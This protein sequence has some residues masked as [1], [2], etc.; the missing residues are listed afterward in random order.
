MF[1]EESPKSFL[2]DLGDLSREPW[3]LLPPSGDFLAEI[4]TRRYDTL[5]Y[6]RSSDRGRRHHALRSQA[7]AQHLACTRRRRKSRGAAAFYNEDDL[8][9]YDVLH[10]DIDVA[11]SP[12]R[13]WI[14][15]RAHGA[16]EGARRRRSSTLTLRLAD[17]LVVQSIASDEFGRLF[18]IRVNNQNTLVD[19][20]AGTVLARDTELTLDDRLRRPPRAAAAGSRNAALDQ[21]RSRRAARRATAADRHAGAELPVQQPQLL[22][23]AGDRS[24][25]YA[26]ATI[27]DHACPRHTTASRAASS[28]RGSRR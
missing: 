28:S 19:Q 15:G 8:A 16:P 2:L 21:R 3:S 23:S 11:V 10:Y 22:V 26:T 7:P 25:D 14:D 20:P 1:R 12:D 5:T 27:R 4:R 18:G 13:Q 24:R 9:D 6:A 17:S